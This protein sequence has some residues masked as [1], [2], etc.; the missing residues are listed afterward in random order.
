VIPVC[1]SAPPVGAIFW[2]DG[3][4]TGRVGVI[5]GVGVGELVGVGVVV[6]VVVGV[7]VAVGVGESD[8]RFSRNEEIGLEGVG[9]SNGE[10]RVGY[11]LPP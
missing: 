10:V 8:G 1:D 11:A 2:I 7:G 6:G 9:Q 5:D 4:P 3:N